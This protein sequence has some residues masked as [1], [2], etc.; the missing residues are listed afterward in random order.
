MEGDSIGEGRRV[1]WA[2]RRIVRE[3]REREKAR[4]RER[5][6]MSRRGGHFQAGFQISKSKLVSRGI[7]PNFDVDFF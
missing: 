1:W 5:E 7:P 2:E 4:G 6:R 3:E